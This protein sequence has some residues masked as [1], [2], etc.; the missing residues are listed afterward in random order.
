MA[1]LVVA[2]PTSFTE[3]PGGGFSITADANGDDVAAAGDLDQASAVLPQGAL[4]NS[5]I[6]N[7]TTFDWGLPADTPV[8]GVR[9][10]W[11][12]RWTEEPAGTTCT[13]TIVAQRSAQNHFIP[14]SF[15]NNAIGW[16]TDETDTPESFPSAWNSLPASPVV[17]DFSSLLFLSI[18]LLNQVPSPG[19]V[20]IDHLEA[21]LYVPDD[22]IV[23][24]RPGISPRGRVIGGLRCRP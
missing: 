5:N 1:R 15:L 6:Y 3:T 17:S 9:L 10:R 19:A 12:H 2:T 20:Q 14:T 16:R 4:T 8:F 23:P 11:R 7:W 13:P 22:V 24:L 21:G 18:Y